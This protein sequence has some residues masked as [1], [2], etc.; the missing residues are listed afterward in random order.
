[1]GIPVDIDVPRYVAAR[2][3]G[4]SEPRAFDEASLHPGTKELTEE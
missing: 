3:E 2:D 4:K 1:M